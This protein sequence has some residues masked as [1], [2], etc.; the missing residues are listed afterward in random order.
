MNKYLIKISEK[1]ELKEHQIRALKKLD[2]NDGVILDHSTGSGK[3]FLMLKAIERAQK[4]DPNG[5]VLFIAPASLTTNLGRQAK[6]LGVNVNFKNVESLSYQ[7]AVIDNERLRKNKYILSVL[8]EG[9]SMRSMDTE[10]SRKLS[11]IIAGADK[12]II[13]TATPAFNHISNIA[14]LVNLAAGGYPVLPTDKK[15][16][17]KRYVSKKIESAPIMQRILGAPSKEVSTLKNKGELSHKLNLYVDSYDNTNDPE[18][19]KHFPTTS[20]RI[21]KVE[22]SPEQKTLYK[23]AEGKLPWVVRLKV[24]SGMPLDKKE[25]SQLNSFGSMVRQVSNSTKSFL[26]QYI[27]PTPK[28]L[29]MANSVEE[30]LKNDKNFKG[31]AYSNYLDSG[32]KDYSEELSKRGIP[33]GLYTGELSRKEKDQMMKDYNEGNHKMLLVSSAGAEGLDLKGSKL[34]Q[35][36]ESHFNESKIKQVI[37]RTARY[38]SHESLPKSERHVNIER[39]HSVFPKNF[40]GKRPTSID[41][42]L[43]DN[44]QHKQGLTEEMKELTKND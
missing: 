28:I 19:G 40:L 32:L 26:P 44:S 5:K 43:Y 16:F 14:P 39:Y 20:E 24:R 10:R 23:Y 37:G 41:E 42:Y 7:K 18:A 9:H 12:R 6:E 36:M 29:A 1:A 8:D 38:N 11:D 15:A 22:M 27:K 21:I 31:V 4:K 25:S 34:M 17:E 13:A 2:K 30:G 35:V 3:T 33:H